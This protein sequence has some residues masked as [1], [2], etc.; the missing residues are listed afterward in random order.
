MI[1]RET[2]HLPARGRGRAYDAF[3]HQQA[4]MPE[5]SMRDNILQWLKLARW[6]DR[7][8]VSQFSDCTMEHWKA[9]AAKCTSGC[10]RDHAQTVLR[11]LSDLWA[12]D[13][14]SISPCG[15]TRPPWEDAGI[16]GYLPAD[17][18]EAGGENKTEPLDPTVIGPLLTW[19][20]RLVEDFFWP[21]GPSA[22]A[23]TPAQ[24]PPRAPGRAWP[25][26]KNVCRSRSTPGISC[27]PR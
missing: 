17:T 21:P 13:Q 16:D 2:E 10:T 23:C 9:Y 8:G 5:L 6:L 24:R 25:P 18:G 14:L 3:A 15:V 20:I 4:A 27:P 26:S 11:W 22:A 12:F 7:Q 1:R 19:S